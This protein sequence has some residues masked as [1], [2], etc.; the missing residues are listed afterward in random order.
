MLCALEAFLRI[1]GE[2]ASTP[3]GRLGLGHVERGDVFV[4]RVAVLQLRV[5][6]VEDVVDAV[7]AQQVR[8]AAGLVEGDGQRVAHIG[9]QRKVQQPGDVDFVFQPAGV[10]VVVA[11]QHFRHLPAIGGLVV[12]RPVRCLRERDLGLLFDPVALEPS[13]RATLIGRLHRLQP[14]ADHATERKD[15][16]PEVAREMKQRFHIPRMPR[17]RR[18]TQSPIRR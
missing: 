1:G 8:V 4:H 2:V 15:Q 14:T 5:T 7:R 18:A 16:P 12:A 11:G 9:H 13:L 17:S 6:V 3:A 10:G